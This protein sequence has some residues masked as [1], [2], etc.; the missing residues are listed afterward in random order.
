V[1]DVVGSTL[2]NVQPGQSE[3]FFRSTGRQLP[4]SVTV[5]PDA[6]GDDYGD[7]SQEPCPEA[8]TVQVPAR[9]CRSSRT[10]N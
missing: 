6:D 7:E 5:E 2:K 1:E 9:R 10:P 8:I 3:P 4:L